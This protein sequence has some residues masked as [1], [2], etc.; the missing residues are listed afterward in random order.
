MSFSDAG[1]VKVN[2]EGDVRLGRR[3]QEPRSHVAGG[4]NCG[5][6]VSF[7][8][9]VWDRAAA[10]VR[11]E[12]AFIFVL[13]CS[14]RSIMFEGAGMSNAPHR[15]RKSSFRLLC[16]ALASV[17]MFVFLNTDMAA[18]HVSFWVIAILRLQEVIE[19]I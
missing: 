12:R 9:Y 4:A 17:T 8:L 5:E 10:R 15:I 14:L 11:A 7:T 1:A 19:I 3:M 2:E 16:A 6:F 13:A 18:I